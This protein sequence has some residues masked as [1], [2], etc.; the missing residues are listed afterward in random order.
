MSPERVHETGIGYSPGLYDVSRAVVGFL[1]SV[2]L[3]KIDITGGEHIPKEGAAVFALKHISHADVA[4]PYLLARDLA[5][6]KIR[7]LARRSL[8]E[9]DAKETKA[10]ITRRTQGGLLNSNSWPQMTARR[11]VGAYLNGFKPILVDPSSRNLGFLELVKAEL[12][13]GRL[14]GIFPE[15]TRKPKLDLLGLQR[16]G[17]SRIMIEN[18][19]VPI[20]P[21]GISGTDKDIRGMRVAINIGEPFVLDDVSLPEDISESRQRRLIG[22]CVADRI[23]ELV[24]DID[25]IPAWYLSKRGYTIKRLKALSKSKSLVREARRVQRAERVA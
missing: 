18:P 12:D 8:I 7:C 20:I 5:G 9:V 11:V 3:V 24:S 19:Q 4:I 22:E 23:G 2:D 25:V 21:I 15:G 10:A 6:R 16:A 1:E 14:I 17:I 13:A